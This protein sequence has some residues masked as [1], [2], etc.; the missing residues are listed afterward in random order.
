[1]PKAANKVE[2]E[3]RRIVA[4]AR[5]CA[6]SDLEKAINLVRGVK[7]KTDG[8]KAARDRAIKILRDEVGFSHVGAAKVLSSNQIMTVIGDKYGV[9]R[10]ALD[11]RLE[12]LVHKEPRLRAAVRTLLEAV[13]ASDPKRYEGF[14]K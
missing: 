11:A 2:A 1:M 10:I 13:E 8:E 4:E 5:L 14:N 7:V 9:P 3:A 12:G 6:G